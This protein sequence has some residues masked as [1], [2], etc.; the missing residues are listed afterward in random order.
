MTETVST[1]W[2][3]TGNGYIM[4][5]KFP[6]SFILDHGFLTKH[7][8]DG[9]YGNVGAIVFADYQ[10]SN[11]GPYQE[12][13][14]IPGKLRYQRHKFYT[15][16]KD[17]VSDR[18]GLENSLIPWGIS[19]ERASF[20]FSNNGK[21]LD[22]LKVTQNGVPIIDITIQPSQR[23]LAFPLRTFFHS[24]HMVQHDP[25]QGKIFQFNLHGKGKGRF[26][27]IMK[28]DVNPELFPNFAFFKHVAI[29]KVSNFHLKLPVAKMK[30]E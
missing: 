18:E 3:F 8:Q 27:E 21:G 4:L 25:D 20:Q 7:F 22:T 16:S 1:T 19:K 6:K 5:F 24:L 9:F 23:G 28:V 29:M 14:F 26:A 10:T 17:F 13:L 30:E 11:A 12:L 2:N 15:I